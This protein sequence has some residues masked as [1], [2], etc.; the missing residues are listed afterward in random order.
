[1]N[2]RFAFLLVPALLFH[3]VAEQPGKL[4]EAIRKKMAELHVAGTSVAV[5][6]NGKVV[7]TKGYGL[8]NVERSI[9]AKP[10]TKY[11]IA[12]TT[13]PF[14]AMAVMMLVE[15]GKVSLDEKVA[16]YLPKLPARYSE[17][18]IRQLLTQTSGVNRDLRADN[19]DDF[20]VEEFWKRLETAPA[21][22]PPGERWEYSNT[23]YI[24][25]GMV[26]ESVT[27]KT[28]GDFL[29]ERIFRP[30]GMK[31]TAYLEPPGKSKDR[32][33]GYDW[34]EGTF[35]PS[36]YFSGGFSAGGLISTVSDMAKWDAAFSTEKLLKRK[37]LEQMFM[38]AKLGNGSLVNFDFRGEP[39]SYGFGWFLTSYRGRKIAT[40]GGVISGF[41][42]QVMRFTDDK[43]TVIVNSNGKSGADR[44]GYAE[45]LAKTVA[46]A[47]VP[48]LPPVPGSV[49]VQ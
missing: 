35:R 24:L 13:K 42:S 43:T 3:A 44:I 5:L 41:S 9:P 16:K 12:S 38:P 36:P 22:F 4:D 31:D 47:Y 27:G 45:A 32:A 21:S 23:G 10:E 46:D 28:Y 26:I 14:T 8:A 25:L 18:T 34:A 48:N 30:L 2:P 7:L 6:R 37:T 17:V 11:Q 1:M 29:R 15:S 19:T 49:P 39:S 33:V 20:T 40:H